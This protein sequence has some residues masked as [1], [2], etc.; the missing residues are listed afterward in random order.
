MS[1]FGRKE[2]AELKKEI[3]ELNKELE[4]SNLR[5]EKLK[6]EN[7]QL[8]E[9]CSRY[10][11]ELNQVN[12]ENEDLKRKHNEITGMVPVVSDSSSDEIEELKK[13]LLYYENHT[14]KLQDRNKNLVNLMWK[15]SSQDNKNPIY[16]IM[17]E[18]REKPEYMSALYLSKDSF[19]SPNEYKMYFLV[20][21]LV[22]ENRDAFGALYVFANTRLADIVKLFE[23][24]YNSGDFSF[25]KMQH[26]NPNKKEI[27]SLIAKHMPNFDDEDYKLA[28]LY[29]LFRMHV[30]ILICADGDDNKIK[31][32]LAIELHGSEH[33]RNSDNPDW[34]KIYNDEFKKSL[35]NIK[36]NAMGV[37]L[38]VIKNEELED[39]DKLTNKVY[40]AVEMCL[41]SPPEPVGNKKWNNRVYGSDG[42]YHIFVDD[43]KTNITNEVAESLIN[44]VKD[45]SDFFQS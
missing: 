41:Q 1:I 2:I 30:D 27:C 40:D 14:K 23:E 11:S 17:D 7:L 22:Y 32:I 43:S 33:D 42:E 34:N 26:K 38:L 20:E 45:M 18:V 24:K 10:Q 13:K 16:N 39:M 37:R 29:P 3:S 9:R 12:K 15:S 35:F 8:S 28:F 6:S 19:F 4:V 31:P 44:Y 36:N 5:F 21:D 25:C